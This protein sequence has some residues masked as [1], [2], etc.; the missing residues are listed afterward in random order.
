M[1]E[2]N[3][4]TVHVVGQLPKIGASDCGAGSASRLP[5]SLLPFFSFVHL[6]FLLLEELTHFLLVAL[7]DQDAC[8]A[9]FP[10]AADDGKS[11]TGN[12]VTPLAAGTPPS[13]FSSCRWFPSRA[14]MRCLHFYWRRLTRNTLP[15]TA[16]HLHPRVG[17]PLIIIIERLSH[18]IG[19]FTF[20]ASGR[21]GRIAEYRHLQIL[22]LGAIPFR[23]FV[24]RKR[25]GLVADFPIGL[26]NHDFVGQ[27]R[28]ATKSGLFVFCP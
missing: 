15:F 4:T 1:Q 19:A 7:R 26:R 10:C 11:F 21:D 28:G 2:P 16:G 25:P 23:V 8:Y 9:C 24:K 17:P 20:E 22:V 3:P 6:Y 5:R 13:L 12:R 14:L 18:R 27:Q